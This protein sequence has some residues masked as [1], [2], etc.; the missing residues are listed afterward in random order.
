MF[1][2][3]GALGAYTLVAY[4]CQ[5]HVGQWVICSDAMIYTQ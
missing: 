1:D 4:I 3:A 5:V 2:V